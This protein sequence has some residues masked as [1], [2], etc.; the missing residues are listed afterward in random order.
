MQLIPYF[1]SRRGAMLSLVKKMVEMESPSAD[2]AA[3]DKCS[4]FIIKNL[5]QLGAQVTE[6]PQVEI[7]DLY[8]AEYIPVGVNAALPGILVLCHVDTVWPVGTLHEMPFYSNGDKLYGPGVLDMKSGIAMVLTALKTLQELNLVPPKKICVY[9]SSCEEISSVVSD[10]FI[11]KLARSSDCVLCM[12]PALPGGALK[13]Q[14]KG[15]KAIVLRTYGKS[16]HAGNPDKGVNAIEELLLQLRAISRLRS[17]HISVNI[18]K[19]MGGENINTVPR[20]ANARLDIRYWTTLQEKKI[21]E[22]LAQ[23]QPQIP[24]ANVTYEIEKQTVAMELTPNSRALFKKAQGIAQTLDIALTAGKTGGG[25]DASLASNMNVPTL[26]GLGPDG[27]GIHAA[28]EHI[29]ISS[30]IEK[31]ALLTEFLLHL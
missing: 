15:R 3:V 10:D 4:R 20:E 26:D 11:R 23:I 14:R 29:L 9:L 24:G 18:G 27:D 13:L 7:G 28:D 22:H 16:A 21:S 19:I 1:R 12:E 31:T 2:K 30:F 8:K 5:K 25:S 6:Y 17:N